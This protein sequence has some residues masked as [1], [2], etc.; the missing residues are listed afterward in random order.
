MNAVHPRHRHRMPV[1][2][3]KE[4]KNAEIIFQNKYKNLSSIKELIYRTVDYTTWVEIDFLPY[5]LTILYVKSKI[6][7]KKYFT[8]YKKD[9][10][11]INTTMY[12]DNNRGCNTAYSTYHAPVYTTYGTIRHYHYFYFSQVMSGHG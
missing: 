11:T 10:K 9:R 5:L 7:N 3:E 12:L 6:P 2:S 4:K 1:T 8:K